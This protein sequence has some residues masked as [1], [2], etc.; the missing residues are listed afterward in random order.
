METVRR[1][2][3]KKFK[4]NL[5]PVIT[6]DSVSRMP[7]IVEFFNS[8][9]PSI[10]HFP[11]EPLF[12]CGRCKTSKTEAPAPEDFVKYLLKARE[13]AAKLG[14]TA[15]YACSEVEGV[16]NYFCGAVDYGFFFVLPEGDVTSCLEICRKS[17]PRA[18]AFIIGKYDWDTKEFVFYEDRIKN[19]RS[20]NVDRIPHCADCFAKYNCAG[21][22]PARCY[23]QS[24]SL[25]DTSKNTDRC[26]MTQGVIKNILLEKLKGDNKK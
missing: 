22:C 19:L 21:D 9:S 3:S 1:L 16:Y 20:R 5:K 25:F 7:E 10:D 13:F 26:R 6:K 15:R 8:I 4:Y 14:K 23:T 24:G 11:L 2:E 12:E 18:S 17:D